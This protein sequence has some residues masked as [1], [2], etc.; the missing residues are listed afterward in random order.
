MTPESF[1]HDHNTH[2]PLEMLDFYGVFCVFLGGVFIAVVSF[3]CELACRT[4][5]RR[6]F[7][8][9]PRHC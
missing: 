3:I 8:L 1:R 6:R 2:R 7:R 5:I 4:K 9:L